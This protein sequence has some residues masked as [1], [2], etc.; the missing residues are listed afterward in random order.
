[1]APLTRDFQKNNSSGYVCVRCGLVNSFGLANTFRPDLNDQECAI[2]R[3]F[4]TVFIA[5][6]DPNSDEHRYARDFLKAVQD[7]ER[8]ETVWDYAVP[9]MVPIILAYLAS[10]PR[11][12]ENEKNAAAREE[13]ARVIFWASDIPRKL[14]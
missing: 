13:L 9:V 12:L 7:K 11:L 8:Q 5:A 3:D 2:V 4:L 10:L 6:T 1:M 14:Q